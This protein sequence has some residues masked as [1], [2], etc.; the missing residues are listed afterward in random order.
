[1]DHKQYLAAEKGRLG[2]QALQNI[3]HHFDPASQMNPEKLLP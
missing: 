1:K 3:F 2:M